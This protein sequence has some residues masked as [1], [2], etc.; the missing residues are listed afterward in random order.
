M[1]RH[2]LRPLDRYVLGEF[3]RIFVT[4]ALGFPIMIIIIDLADNLDKYLARS[5]SAGDIAMSYV[6]WLPD[7]MF[8]VLPAAV[9]FATVFSIGTFTRHS[10]IAAAKA[11]GMSFYR[12]IAPI[13]LGAVFAAGFGLVLGELVPA[14]NIRRK[15]LLGEVAMTRGTDR[16]N[17]AYSA[18]GGRIYKVGSLDA[19]RGVMNLVE[20]ERKGSGPEYPTYVLSAREGLWNAER[21]WT[22]R[23]GHLHILPDSMTDIALSFDSLRAVQMTEQ[24]EE[25]TA[26]SKAPEEMGY[27]ELGRFIEA[28]E[29]SGGDVNKLRVDRMLKLAIPVTCIIIALFGAPLATSTERGGTAYG[30]GISLATTVVFLM[31]IQLTR[32]V[33]EKG[34]VPPDLA[35]WIPSAIFA[36]IGTVLM[37]RVKT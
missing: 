6:Y 13:F 18:Q 31:L 17:F 32:A 16:S 24:P 1:R 30:V 25:L 26:N 35:A 2:I 15:Q 7:S 10:E 8:M 4:T 22:L 29:R 3:W 37:L 36:I 14:A 12:F 28:M 19:E 5:I 21:G 27:G 9:L 20:I 33:G 34:I 11:S 23:G